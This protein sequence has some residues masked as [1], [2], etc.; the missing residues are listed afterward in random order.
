MHLLV[1]A[2]AFGGPMMLNI[3]YFVVKGVPST[4]VLILIYHYSKSISKKLVL[5]IVRKKCRMAA[6]SSGTKVTCKGQ[7]ADVAQR[8]D[9]PLFW[10]RFC[11]QK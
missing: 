1:Y 2:I 8:R 11:I 3:G 4:R 7:K 5:L 6:Y 10:N 9:S